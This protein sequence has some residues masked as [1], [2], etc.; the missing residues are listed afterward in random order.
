MNDIEVVEADSQ[1]LRRQFITY[2]LSL[3]ADVPQY[4]QHL[5]VERFEFF[6]PEKN[7]FFRTAKVRLFLARRGGK[8]VGRIATCLNYQHNE[9]HMD[10][11]GFFGFFDTE[12]DYEVA[13]RLLKV[14]MITLKKEGMESM[15]GPLNFSTNHEG[16]F[17]I[18]GFE[19]PPTIMMT[20][21]H[22]YQIELAERF[23]FTKVMDW[24]A[25][26]VTKE[27][28]RI[29]RFQPIVDRLRKRNRVTI[30]PLNMKQF[31][32]DVGQIKDVYNRAWAEN[33]GFVPLDDAQITYMA[34]QFK[35]IVDPDLVFI[36][37]V[38]DE[39]VAFSMALPDINQALVHLN[40][41]LFP[42]GLAQLLWHTKVRNKVD[43]I[44][45]V[46][47]GVIPEYQKR[48]I[49]TLLYVETVDKAIE[50]GYQQAEM[51]WVLETNALMRR[52]LVEM[53]ATPRKRYR[54]VELP[55]HNV[56]YASTGS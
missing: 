18:E 35:Q 3:Y 15:R 6:D 23:G 51:S 55:L 46:T 14:A 11:T 8:I 49:D 50:R 53:G 17:L 32:A 43:R 13:Q 12:N 44:R 56:A 27:E 5:L 48:G 38:D 54:L 37:L 20:W 42:F 30:R 47:F 41:R 16:G 33:W 9:F 52:A 26:Q 45:M 19:Q 7:P 25:Y 34:S 4:V 29:S 1:S 24:L 22:P 40:G 2:P 21:T 31:N 39:P 10:K 36:A 28:L